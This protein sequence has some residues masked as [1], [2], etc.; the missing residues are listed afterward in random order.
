M[1]EDPAGAPAPVR[2]SRFRIL[3]QL[4]LSRYIAS[5]VKVWVA[6]WLEKVRE[7]PATSAYASYPDTD[8]LR[9]DT[10]ALYHYLATWLRQ[11]EWDPRI[12]PHYQRIGRDRRREGFPLSQVIAAILLAKRT[13]WD[14]IVEDKQLSV[15]LE[16]EVT[17]AISRFYDRAIYNTVLGYEEEPAG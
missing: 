14:R 11:G 10:E 16:L 17:R 15:A 3:P 12:D 2:S 7:D 6:E 9:R 13:L 8:E 1:N 4:R 5:H